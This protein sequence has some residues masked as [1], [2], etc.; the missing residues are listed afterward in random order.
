[1][2]NVC[3]LKARTDSSFSNSMQD[4]AIQ[5]Y[6]IIGI[7][8][9][10]KTRK[11]KSLAVGM[12]VVFSIVLLGIIS[13]AQPALSKP[14]KAPQAIAQQSGAQL[15]SGLNEHA[16]LLF[17]F[18]VPFGIAALISQCATLKQISYRLKK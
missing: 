9:K 6:R 13:F 11:K 3:D 4:M 17:L 18:A 10:H 1:M 7:D 12:S 8:S 15:G 5:R 14:A 16:D 2:I